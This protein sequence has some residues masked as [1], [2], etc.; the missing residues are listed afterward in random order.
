MKKILIFWAILLVF[1]TSLVASSFND[2]SVAT[3]DDFLS[4]LVNPAAMGFGNAGGMGYVQ[5]FFDDKF[6]Q[7][8]YDFIINFDNLGYSYSKRPHDYWHRIALGSRLGKSNFY[9]GSDYEWNKNEAAFNS[10]FLYRPWD[11]LSVG[12]NWKKTFKSDNS[13]RLGFALRPLGYVSD[14]WT[15]LTLAYD[16]TYADEE[17]NK[18]VLSVELE[19]AA[20][21]K[22]N[23]SNDFE[24][25]EYSTGVSISFSNFRLGGNYSKNDVSQGLTYA[26]ISARKFKNSLQTVEQNKFYN[27]KLKGKVVD[28]KTSKKIGPI[29]IVSADEKTLSEALETIKELKEDKR[30]MGLVFKSGN[31]SA[32]RA[33]FQEIGDALIDFKKEGKKVVYYFENTTNV[34]YS[35]AAS[36]ADKIYLNPGGSLLLNGISITSPYIKNLLDT[37]GV[38]VLNFR[39]HAYKT[40][41]NMF[42]EKHMTEEERQ[43]YEKMLS[44]LYEDMVERISIGRGMTIK[45]VRSIIDAGP[46]FIA[47]KAKE[48]NLVDDLIYED[49]IE[50]KLK[51][52]FG[53][54][55]IID[56]YKQ[57][58]VRKDWSD[59]KKDKIAIIYASGTI[60]SGEGVPGKTIGS[61]TLTKYLKEAREDDS[62]KGIILRVNSGG[63][64]ALASE[65]IAHQVQKCKKGENAKPIIASMSG[66][67]ASG[68][69][70]IS[71]PA[72][73]II[74][75]SETITG[76]IGVIALVPNFTELYR[77][78]HI[79]WDT[80]KKGENADIFAT[81]SPLTDSAK[82]KIRGSVE[83]SYWAFVDAVAQGRDM[84]REQVHKIAQGKVWTGKSAKELGLVDELGGIDYSIKV[85]RE[86]CNIPPKEEIEVVQYPR[87]EA[88]IMTI[89]LSSGMSLLKNE[90]ELP[91]QLKNFTKMIEKWQKFNDERIL[92]LYPYEFWQDTE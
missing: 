91:A 88:G 3:T 47:S 60:H 57:N 81:D 86:M 18:G 44:D 62:I 79:N 90:V 37:L 85:L 30:I 89:D 78:I 22:F 1:S 76:S 19:P 43:V 67:A 41:G 9:V 48:K 34:N 14:F 12:A 23:F 40:A 69:Y 74:A 21:F 52:E 84:S 5:H 66:A 55:E 71:S 53:E 51:Q 75:Q 32:S 92:Y 56:K 13:V 73:K 27:Y 42:T 77:K 70:F 45:E 10:S 63:G 20:G 83:H 2:F 80:V 58:H 59:E 25:E 28:Q 68:G 16:R 82:E 72:D 64:S 35:L 61:K 87:A 4:T 54:N 17:W 6:E 49:E 24:K 38:E 36:V 31:I 7:E 50:Q 15:G 46:Y 26:N 65:I 29:R 33:N 39:S 11:F 8:A